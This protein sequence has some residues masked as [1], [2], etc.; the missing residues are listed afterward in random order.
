MVSPNI[1]RHV[2]SSRLARRTHVPELAVLQQKVSADA[3]ACCERALDSSSFFA[4]LAAGKAS[5]PLLQYVFLQY[6][7]FRDQLHRWFGLCIMRA[8][9]SSDPH[10][11]RAVMALADHVFTD[12]RDSHELMYDEFLCLLGVDEAA[13]R[14]ATPSAASIAYMRSFVDEFAAER[15][16]FYGA[17]AA[18]SGRELCVALRNRRLL[19][20]Y[21]VPRG[22]EHPAWLVLHSELEEEHFQDV[23]RPVL[24]ASEPDSA[25]FPAHLR[26]M[27][28]AIE[29]HVSYFDQ[30]LLEYEQ[31]NYGLTSALGEIGT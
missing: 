31:T 8:P 13:L 26:A 30:L 28:R 5:P 25:A 17:L 18:L 14:G 20:Q 3:I 27:S 24:E 22:L 21:F 16:D 7:F 15:H 11:K 2:S 29:G 23:M 6:L 10:Q 4:V 9:S 19:R 12:L 1:V